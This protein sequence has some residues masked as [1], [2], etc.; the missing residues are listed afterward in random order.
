MGQM[1]VNVQLGLD[2][3]QSFQ[4]ARADR[5]CSAS[6][7]EPERNTAADATRSTSDDDALTVEFEPHLFASG[8]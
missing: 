4:I 5:H 8:Q 2:G 6:L 3:F 1:A 7:R